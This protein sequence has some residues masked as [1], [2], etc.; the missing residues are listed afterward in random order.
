MGLLSPGTPQALTL[1]FSKSSLICWCS[2][3][4]S[5]WS[6]SWSY[7]VNMASISAS[8]WPFLKALRGLRWTY[9]VHGPART[10]KHR[11]I[12]MRE[13]GRYTSMLQKDT[14]FPKWKTF[15]YQHLGQE[16]PLVSELTCT[17]GAPRFYGAALT[18][19]GPAEAHQSLTCPHLAGDSLRCHL[20]CFF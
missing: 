14:C 19:S 10:S 18:L 1:S 12:G 20:Q 13:E 3:S 9:A 16:Q 6:P 17:A 7:L 2:R 11:N 4:V 8:V 15:F 5:S